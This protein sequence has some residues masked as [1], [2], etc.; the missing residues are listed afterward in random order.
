[1]F[2]EAWTASGKELQHLFMGI[3]WP[4]Q[5]QILSRSLNWEHLVII[6][7]DT[8][9]VR[10][11]RGCQHRD[12]RTGRS[13]Q[14]ITVSFIRWQLEWE[15]GSQENDHMSSLRKQGGIWEEKKIW[16]M[17]FQGEAHQILLSQRHWKSSPRKLICWFPYQVDNLSNKMQR[18]AKKAILLW[19]ALK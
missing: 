10:S 12:H 17:M 2:R 18:A 5:K 6:E 4:W 13:P 16:R 1:M 19:I 7:C 15:T 14:T 3:M 8:P 9:L 11:G